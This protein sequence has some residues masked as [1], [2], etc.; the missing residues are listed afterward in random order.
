[1]NNFPTEDPE[2]VQPSCEHCGLAIRSGSF[3]LEKTHHRF[4]TPSAS[5]LVVGGTEG[6]ERPRGFIP[7]SFSDGW[8]HDDPRG[9]APMVMG[10]GDHLIIPAV[11]NNARHTHA[12]DYLRQERNWR[13]NELEKRAHLGA[14][15]E[16]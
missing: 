14:Q 1:M 4:E 9:S 8:Y 7:L 13:M 2:F 16:D 11:I 12:T 3:E 15:F 10:R 6:I 5:G